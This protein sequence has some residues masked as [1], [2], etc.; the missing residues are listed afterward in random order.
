MYKSQEENKTLLISFTPF[1][2]HTGVQSLA[3]APKSIKKL[4]SGDYLIEVTTKGHAVNLLKSQIFINCPVKITPH[5]SLNSSKGIIRCRELAGMRDPEICK[6]LRDQGVTDVRRISVRR[7]GQN[8]PTNTFVLT[9]DTTVIPNR[10]F[11]GYMSTKVEIYI[12]SPLRCFNC[13]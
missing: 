13:Q 1:A 9:F 6:E 7:D 12:P 8:K 10:I 2:I 4:N 5:R 3:G 11:I